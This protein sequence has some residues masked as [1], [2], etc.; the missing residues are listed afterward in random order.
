M[1][2]DTPAHT[3][4]DARNAHQHPK[5]EL[6]GESLFV[7][8]RTAEQNLPLLAQ[9]PGCA[10]YAVL[11]TIPAHRLVW[12]ELSH[13]PELAQPWAWPALIVSARMLCGGLYWWLERARWL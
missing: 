12:H 13:M 9:G 10:L 6:Y 5:I 4:E 3:A 8:A 11:D 7:V 1:S 2:T